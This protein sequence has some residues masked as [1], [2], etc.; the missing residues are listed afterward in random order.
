MSPR[1]GVCIYAAVSSV[2]SA[3]VLQ[4]AKE[5]FSPEPWTGRGPTRCAPSLGFGARALDSRKVPWRQFCLL[6]V[7]EVPGGESPAETVWSL[8][9]RGSRCGFTHRLCLHQ[10]VTMAL[11]DEPCQRKKFGLL[12]DI[13]S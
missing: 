9:H 13:N 4:E 8:K 1:L 6:E 11:A 7:L 12:V 3:L 5:G 10:I 2:V